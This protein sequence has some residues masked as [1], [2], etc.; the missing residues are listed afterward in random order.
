LPAQA[1]MRVKGARKFEHAIPHL[2][3]LP[4]PRIR[5]NVP[6]LGDV[7]KLLDHDQRQWPAVQRFGFKVDVGVRSRFPQRVRG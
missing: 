3:W 2:R 6:R 4:Q 5:R 1:M 7:H